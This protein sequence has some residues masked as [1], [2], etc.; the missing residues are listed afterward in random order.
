MPNAE[1][2][3]NL[4][5]FDAYVDEN[6]QSADLEVNEVARPAELQRVLKGKPDGE[7]ETA[8]VA[9]GFKGEDAT[10]ETEA[11]ISAETLDHLGNPHIAGSEGPVDKAA[12]GRGRDKP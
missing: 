8:R 2:T 10:D 9:S 3:E 12:A 5:S 7:P 6:G 11:E 1:K 4:K